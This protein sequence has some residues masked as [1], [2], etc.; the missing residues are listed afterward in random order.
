MYDMCTT[1]QLWC[2]KSGGIRSPGSVSHLCR[3]LADTC[4]IS[5]YTH[6]FYSSSRSCELSWIHDILPPLPTP[7]QSFTVLLFLHMTSRLK[8]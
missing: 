3:T 7:P 1:C 4:F 5:S 8:N 2:R 6:L